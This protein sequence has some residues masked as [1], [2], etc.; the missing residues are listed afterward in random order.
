MDGLGVGRRQQRSFVPVWNLVEQRSPQ[1][2]QLSSS[3]RSPALQ[4]LVTPQVVQYS[5]S[6]TSHAKVRWSRFRVARVVRFVDGVAKGCGRATTAFSGTSSDALGRR[7]VRIASNS[8]IRCVGASRHV[9][10]SGSRIVADGS[11]APAHPLKLFASLLSSL[12]RACKRVPASSAAWPARGQRIRI[13]DSIG[14]Y[15]PEQMGWRMTFPNKK[16][17]QHQT[18]CPARHG[19]KTPPAS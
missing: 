5:I 8:D 6:P 9:K 13:V 1:P 11:T 14:L 19:A 2:S 3:W 7:A 4:A 12:A 18:Q 10:T 16:E 17:R 15:V